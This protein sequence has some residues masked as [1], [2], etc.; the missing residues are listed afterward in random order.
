MAS[1]SP[2]L[3]GISPVIQPTPYL[4]LN[5]SGLFKTLEYDELTPVCT[6]V[7][8]HLMALKHKIHECT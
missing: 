4:L 7:T 5:Y 8:E 3:E 6:R 1:K 2:I